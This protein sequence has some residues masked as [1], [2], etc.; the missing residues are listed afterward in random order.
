MSFHVASFL[1]MEPIVE[2]N[3]Q[4][5]GVRTRAL[6]LEGDG[7]PLILLHGFGDSADT[8]RLLFDR[9]RKQGRAAVALDMPGFGAAALLDRE[10]PI[11]PQLDS[12]AEA[13]IER[14]AAESPSGEVVIAGNSLGGT[15]ALRAA[16]RD[17][18]S[19]LAG[20]VP[21]APAG[22]EMPTWFAAIQS[23]PLVRAM[24]RSPVP[25]PE[26][27]VRRAVGSTYRVLAFASPRKAD[28]AVVGAFT[29]HFGSQRDVAR[30][31]ATGE[32]LMPEIKAPFDLGRVRCPVLVVWGERDR[33]VA[34][35]GAD[36]IVAAL[37][38]TRI[39]LLP[40]CGHCPQIEEPDRL[41]ELLA[42]FPS[43]P[44]S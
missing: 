22:L 28:D 42:A 4:L 40:R 10:A 9:L 39:E 12:F 17:E 13:A 16:E 5:D 38:E 3:L 23:A 1:V 44:A 14:W 35:K 6:E 41:A 18:G 27:A 7:P 36:L 30:M 19:R 26:S 29:T 11:I 21:V 43:A 15:V 32:R 33:M 37:P 8:W 34:S 20:V 31:L 25:I 2:H 24:L